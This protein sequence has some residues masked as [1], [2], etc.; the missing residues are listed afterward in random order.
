MISSL[1]ALSCD[2]LDAF[3]VHEI[4]AEPM[5]SQK[6]TNVALSGLEGSIITI[7]QNIAQVSDAFKGRVQPGQTKLSYQPLLQQMIEDSAHLYIEK[8]NGEVISQTLKTQAFSLNALYHSLIGEKLIL[9]GAHAE[10]FEGTLFAVQSNHLLL[11]NEEGS[12]MNVAIDKILSL[13]TDKL[14]EKMSI[15]PQLSALYQ[16][17]ESEEIEGQVIF[18]TQGLQWAPHYRLVLEEDDFGELKGQLISHI[19]I[20]NQTGKTLKD[21][22]VQVVAGNLNVN[23]TRPLPRN[24]CQE[25]YALASASNDAYTKAAVNQDWEDYKAYLVPYKINLE[26]SERV[27]MKLFDTKDVHVEKKYVLHNYEHDQGEK[28]PGVAYHISNS[29]ENDLDQALPAGKIQVFNRSKGLINFTGEHAIEQTPQGKNLDIITGE[30]FDLRVQRSTQTKNIKNAKNKLIAQ[31][32]T[33]TLSC[34]NGKLEDTEIQLHEHIHGEKKLLESSIDIPFSSNEQIFSIKV[35]KGSSDEN[36]YIISYTY[37]KE[38]A[39]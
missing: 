5:Q 12:L 9:E 3:K 4:S 21:V 8:G 35:P 31:E 38:M 23:N 14:H 27:S 24:R 32:V 20:A 1:Q 2:F 22:I 16:T 37:R 29:E 36:P 26:P 17:S 34:M 19:Q 18:L 7:Y 13:K 10:K 28:H 39:N 33:V 25:M 15:K 30:S 6:I 11:L